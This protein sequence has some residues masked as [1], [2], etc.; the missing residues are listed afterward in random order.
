M[1][2]KETLAYEIK[3][4]VEDNG[5]GFAFPSSSL[6]VEKLPF[7]RPEAYPGPEAHPDAV[8]EEGATAP[9]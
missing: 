4:I 1:A 3:R 7:G 9:D 6:Y 8:P 5:A 2:I